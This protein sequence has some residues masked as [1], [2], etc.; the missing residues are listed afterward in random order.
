[1]KKMAI[2]LVIMISA[3]CY[4]QGTGLITV[5]KSDEV[6]AI[7]KVANKWHH[8]WMNSDEKTFREL[9]KPAETS[10]Q[11]RMFSF[12]KQISP[13]LDGTPLKCLMASRTVQEP[14]IATVHLY[15]MLLAGRLNP[16]AIQMSKQEGKWYVLGAGGIQ[17]ND[18]VTHHRQ[19]A[20]EHARHEIWYDEN[21]PEW[22]KPGQKDS[23]AAEKINEIKVKDRKLYQESYGYLL[24]EINNELLKGDRLQRSQ[25]L[26]VIRQKRLSMLFDES[27]VKPLRA[28]LKSED[29]EV[30]KLARRMH[31][32]LKKKIRRKKK[33]DTSK[34]PGSAEE[35]KILADTYKRKVAEL[36]KSLAEYR[37]KKIF[38][39]FITV[40]DD[41]V[42]PLIYKG[43]LAGEKMGE[44]RKKDPE[45][46]KKST[47]GKNDREA[48]L[49]ISAAA[50]KGIYE[51]FDKSVK[52][53]Q[54]EL[55][56]GEQEK[57]YYW[58]SLMQFRTR[59]KLIEKPYEKHCPF[60]E[61]TFEYY[62]FLHQAGQA[63]TMA[64]SPLI[65]MI[66]QL[67]DELADAKEEVE[68]M[69]TWLQRGYAN[70]GK[71][72]IPKLYKEPYLNKID[73]LGNKH[74]AL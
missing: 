14:L 40:L 20:K 58:G 3:F 21:A 5:E 10:M 62:Q 27:S 68:I 31:E 51:K 34:V 7:L 67:P 9:M 42:F 2:T 12:G 11:D 45:V 8:A 15:P 69:H 25:L 65:E 44:M 38:S 16:F 23:V 18:L 50:L 43:R 33:A 4:G 54:L 41:E 53:G 24:A 63:C 71:T 22:L 28:C 17:I 64:S 32:D 30:V 66:K 72:E 74:K 36:D 61:G 37:S 52:Q 47:F 60:A 57:I 73:E 35:F 49:D 6:E 59:Q 48:L 56:Y 55:P 39:D 1:M 46:Y 13:Y 29:A 26:T 70:R 19:W